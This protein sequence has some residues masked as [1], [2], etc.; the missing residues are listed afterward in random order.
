MEFKA[1]RI[2]RHYRQ[3]INAGSDVILPLLCP[4]RETEWLD[5]WEYRMIYSESGRTELGAIF[6][7]SREGEED[8]VWI[9]TKH[10]LKAHEV[11][12]ARV[13]PNSRTCILNIAVKA[14]DANSSYVD[15]TYTYT[16]IS[17][18]GNAFIDN[19]TEEMFLGM[20]TF[21]EKSMNYFLET[22]KKLRKTA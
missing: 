6:S 19:Y 3:I 2:S 11:D 12:F 20:A 17:D 14:K 5:G 22:G 1:K 9:L 13:T 4:D 15:I 8:T 18:H 21:W 16:G 10:D 7:T